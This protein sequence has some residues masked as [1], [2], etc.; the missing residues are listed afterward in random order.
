MGVVSNYNNL[1]WYSEHKTTPLKGGIVLLPGRHNF[2]Y[3]LLRS[4]SRNLNC[5]EIGL[6][7]ITPP[8][9]QG[10]YPPPNGPNDQVQAV[11]GLDRSAKLIEKIIQTI[12]EQHS[13]PREK[14]VVAGFSMGAVAGVH[15]AIHTNDPVAALVCHS[16]AILEPWK[17][18]QARHSMP[19]ILNHGQD[20]YCFEWEE[21]Y[22]PMKRALSKKGYDLWLVERPEGNHT[23]LNSDVACLQEFLEEKFKMSLAWSAWEN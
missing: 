3:N 16:G 9:S 13:L 15:W 1:Y 5:S 7:S 18:P 17:V 19:I 22:L 21:R 10:W 8:L 4:Y 11:M 20:D 6:F 2:G 12:Q 14:I 23:I